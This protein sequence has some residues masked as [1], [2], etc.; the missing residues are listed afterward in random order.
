MI[1]P[2]ISTNSREITKTILE[3]DY[4]IMRDINHNQ[5]IKITSNG[6]VNLK[7]FFNLFITLI[8]YLNM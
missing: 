8:S 3:E 7:V 2:L 1:K 4:T 6:N 5:P